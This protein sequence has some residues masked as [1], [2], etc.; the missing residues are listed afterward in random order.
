MTQSF[1]ARE[2]S[3][4]QDDDSILLQELH[5]SPHSQFRTGEPA[6]EK[7]KCCN[8]LDQHS[9]SGVSSL[10]SD[11]S[12][13]LLFQLT[14]RPMWLNWISVADFQLPRY[15]SHFSLP[16]VD[17]KHTSWY[18]WSAEFSRQVHFLYSL[19][20][21]PNREGIRNHHYFQLPRYDSHFSLPRVDILVQWL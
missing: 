2:Q 5:P 3:S 7:Q 17:I 4:P 6:N 12:Y 14:P 20:W 11:C 1:I 8:G 13:H 15:D 10:A 18:S 19:S 21:A 16:R 9:W